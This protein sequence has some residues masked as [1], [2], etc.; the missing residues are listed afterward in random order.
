MSTPTRATY[1]TM[2]EGTSEDYAL[3]SRAEEANNA[4]LVSR[5]LTLV[6]ARRRGAGVSD[7]PAGPLTAVS[8]PGPRR[9]AVG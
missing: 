6:E 9:R 4:G 2:A 8:D 3:I 5:V 7:Q 1:R